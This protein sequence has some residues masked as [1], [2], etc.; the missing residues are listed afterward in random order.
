MII[1]SDGKN[2]KYVL[3]PGDITSAA[4][5]QRHHISARQ[6][7]LLYG[8]H[9]ETCIVWPEDTRGYDLKWLHSLIKLIPKYNGDY[10]LPKAK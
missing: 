8:V 2:V 5:G 9:P 10:T 7:Q 1:P 6:L 3:V 4:D